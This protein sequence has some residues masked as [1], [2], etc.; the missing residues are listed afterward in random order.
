MLVA[1]KEIS[2]LAKKM[3]TSDE[4][5]TQKIDKLSAQFAVRF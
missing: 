5:R 2:D 4:Q 1:M 3:E